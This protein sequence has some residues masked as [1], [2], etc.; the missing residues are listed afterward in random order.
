MA[1]C[2]NTLAPN[3]SCSPIRNCPPGSVTPQANPC[4]EDPIPS[5][6]VV[7][8]LEI[9]GRSFI[10]ESQ[11]NKFGVPFPADMNL[12]DTCYPQGSFITMLFNECYDLDYYKYLYSDVQDKLSWPAVVRRR[13][14]VYPVSARYME[15][16]D[17]GLNTFSLLADDF[18]LLDALLIYR[19]DSTGLVVVDTTGVTTTLVYDATAGITI[20]T[21]DL[22]VLSTELSK[23]IFI[24]LDLVVNKNISNYFSN[25]PISTD[26]SLQTIYE[27]F[28]ISKYFDYISCLAI[29]VRLGARDPDFAG[30][31]YDPSAGPPGS[32]PPGGDTECDPTNDN[33]A[34]PS[35]LDSPY[36][37]TKRC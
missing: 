3:D 9:Y 24:Y 34:T 22:D 8:E 10:L 25:V 13:L 26:F 29:D 15:L 27:L 18:T 2:D 31:P 21:T 14:N 19:Q 28:V 17:N 33:P 6:I 7:P 5:T 35:I 1:R 30:L 16:A 11:V 4:C 20:L 36:D 23:L 32:N 37:Q 12:D